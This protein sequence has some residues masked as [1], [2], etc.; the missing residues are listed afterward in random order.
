[1]VLRA[2]SVSPHT[3]VTSEP[4]Y[5]VGTAMIGSP[6]VSAIALAVPVVEPAADAEQRV[7]AGRGGPFPG[8]LGDRDRD[9][10][11]DRREHRDDPLPQRRGELAG[12]RLLLLR[13]DQQDPR[14]PDPVGL[15]DERACGPCQHRTRP[16][17]AARR[18]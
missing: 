10:R 15:V 3:G 8:R 1:M 9:V 2:A 6:V 11:A 16:G 12:Q 18:T 14:G 5:V 13:R 7:G 4:A 17:P